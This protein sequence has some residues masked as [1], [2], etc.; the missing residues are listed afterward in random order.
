VQDLNR[1]R[2][3]REDAD[4]D[5]DERCEAADAQEEPG[6]AEEGRVRAR[7]GLQAA[8]AGKRARELRPAPAGIGGRDRYGV[9]GWSIDVGF[10]V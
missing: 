6:T 8:A 1:P 7:V 9:C 2:T 3:Q 10:P 4:A 5:A